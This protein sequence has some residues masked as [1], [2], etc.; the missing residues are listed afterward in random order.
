M[1]AK[2]LGLWTERKWDGYR[3]GTCPGV[4]SSFSAEPEPANKSHL[5]RPKPWA[6]LAFPWPGSDSYRHSW[7]RSPGASLWDAHTH[8]GTYTR[9]PAA[10]PHQLPA[11][12]GLCVL[13][14]QLQQPHPSDNE[15]LGLWQHGVRCRDRYPGGLG[16]L[17]NNGQIPPLCWRNEMDCGLT[18]H[19]T[20][21]TLPQWDMFL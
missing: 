8:S 9:A 16:L 4:F 18:L 1:K 21:S 20:L 13:P 10:S 14:V 2:T 6:L 19:E 3:D 12:P 11:R 17:R 7:V 5:M 15:L